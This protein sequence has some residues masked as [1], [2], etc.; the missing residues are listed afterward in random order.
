MW[1]QRKNIEETLLDGLLK[2]DALIT[3]GGVSVGEYD[4]VKSVLSRLGQIN[5]WRVAMKPG[6]PQAFGLVDGKPIF[7]FLRALFHP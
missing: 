7:G 5:F 4:V 3:S 2:A 6:K 1:R